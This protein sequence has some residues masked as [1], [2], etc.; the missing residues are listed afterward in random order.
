MGLSRR[1]YAEHRGCSS[2]QVQNRVTQGVLKRSILGDGSID[3]EVADREW[4]K[5]SASAVEAKAKAAPKRQAA[6]KSKKPAATP[7]PVVELDEEQR[8]A[9]VL[10]SSR[11]AVRESLDE[12][13]EKH[14]EVGE[15]G[16]LDD[17]S[18]ND[19]RTANE[20]EKA[21]LARLKRRQLEGE[22]IEREAAQRLVFGWQRQI[23]DAWLSW[24]GQV[25][26]Q[27]A[28]DLGIED[29]R[30]VTVALEGYV[31][32]KLEELASVDPPDFT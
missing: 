1:E 22:L 9:L 31:R 15:D 20:Y 29:T 5:G 28:A 11:R 32:E 14:G 26:P 25:G 18:Y 10:D 30:S 27:I 16:D 13:A 24:P 2:S 12:A 23:R 17:I 3:A 8:E 19:A 4:G 7:E 21:E 6:K